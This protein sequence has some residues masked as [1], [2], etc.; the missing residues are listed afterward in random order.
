L[1]EEIPDKKD[2]KSSEKEEKPSSKKDEKTVEP[3]SKEEKKS[4]LP[5]PPK[6]AETPVVNYLIFRKKRREGKGRKSVR[7]QGRR[8]LLK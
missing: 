3:T 5:K 7:R 8:R 1:S 2:L 4:D 6:T